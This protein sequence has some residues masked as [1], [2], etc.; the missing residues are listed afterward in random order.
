MNSSVQVGAAEGIETQ[1]ELA[2]AHNKFLDG[3]ALRLEA[4]LKEKEDLH[5]QLHEDLQRRTAESEAQYRASQAERESMLARRDRDSKLFTFT[6]QGCEGPGLSGCLPRQIIDD[7]PNSALAHI[8][9]GKWQY[10]TDA[11]GRAVINSDPAHWPI[12]VRWLSF[13]TV[14]PSPTSEF[15]SEYKYWQLDRRLEAIAFKNDGARSAHGDAFEL[16]RVCQ[17]GSYGFTAECDINDF[18]ERLE[19]ASNTSSKLILPFR[20]AGQDWNIRLDQNRLDFQMLNGSTV[21]VNH[22]KFT[23]GMGSCTWQRQSQKPFSHT[24]EKGGSAGWNRKK[25]DVENLMHPNL[26]SVEGYMHLAA[27]IMFKH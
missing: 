12:I 9:N 24:L 4:N 6:V 15:L 27:T 26:M 3:L 1:Q 16:R 21:E 20:A 8:Y 13:G 18:C 10:S 25:L 19:K 17:D 2:E 5:E 11:K 7:E 22:M 14:P 23:L